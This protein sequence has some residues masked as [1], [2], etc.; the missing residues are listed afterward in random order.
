MKN[1]ILNLVLI[2]FSSG[3]ALAYTPG[4]EDRQIAQALDEVTKMIDANSTIS[5]SATSSP[6]SLKK[7]E[8][9]KRKFIKKT[10]QKISKMES[11]S[12]VEQEEYLLSQNSED[13]R[14]VRK[15]S[16]KILRRGSLL[17]KLAS[18][19]GLTVKDL[20]NKLEQSATTESEEETAQNL[21]SQ[22]RQAGGFEFVLKSRLD[23]L[24]SMSYQ[25]Y[26]SSIESFTQNSNSKSLK[27]GILDEIAMAIWLTV[28]ILAL[29]MTTAILLVIL[30][31]LL[32]TG[33]STAAILLP[34]T[35]GTG[36]SLLII[37]SLSA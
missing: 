22:A 23:K 11:L 9:N 35:I 36:L 18:K 13:F 24:I 15:V 33:A 6:M 30:A 20:K 8:R 27:S 32:I 19:S 28:G 14:K 37:V 31:I 25:D 17:R 5:K 4:V 21:L 2:A 10:T 3:Q 29:I 7:F 12:L 16:S 26:L 1:F 34:A